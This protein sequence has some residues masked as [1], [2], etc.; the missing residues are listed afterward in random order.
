MSSNSSIDSNGDDQIA[1][2]DASGAVQDIFG[3][4]GEQ[5]SA[6][7]GHLFTDGRAERIET[8]TSANSTW[9]VTEWNV[10]SGG[11]NAPEGFD[12]GAWVGLSTSEVQGCM[13]PTATNYNPDATVDDAT[14]VYDE[15]PG[16]VHAS[17]DY[18][19]TVPMNLGRY[20]AAHAGVGIETTG[21]LVSYA[22]ALGGTTAE[23]VTHLMMEVLILYGAEPI[24][25]RFILLLTLMGMKMKAGF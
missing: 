25:L 22:I 15:V 13:D 21:G 16:D 23:V 2:L 10:V 3:V 11:V 7:N 18:S 4:P 8:V 17:I 6:S 1:L 9:D 5:G 20:G 24:A 19:S 14:C 12:P